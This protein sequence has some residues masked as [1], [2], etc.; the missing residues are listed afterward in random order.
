MWLILL[1]ILMLFLLYLHSS[2][3]KIIDLYSRLLWL[4]LL[5]SFISLLCFE[6]TLMC[7]CKGK[8]EGGRRVMMSAPQADG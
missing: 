4:S 6:V 7:E 2:V 5:F 8:C 1:V 3:S